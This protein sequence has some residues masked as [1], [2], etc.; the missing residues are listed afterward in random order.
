MDLSMSSVSISIS[1]ESWYHRNRG[2]SNL[3]SL[4]TVLGVG[5][6][7]KALMCEGLG[8]S[9]HM[10]SNSREQ[11]TVAEEGLERLKTLTD[12]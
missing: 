7:L 4:V 1:C 3:I 12:R 5:R 10:L 6:E 2:F 11:S 9:F 8:C